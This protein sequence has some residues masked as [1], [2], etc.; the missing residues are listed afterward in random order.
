MSKLKQPDR[1]PVCYLIIAGILLTQLLL[2]ALLFHP[3]II[4]FSRMESSHWL[5]ILSAAIVVGIL[6]FLY[7]VGSSRS[8]FEGHFQ[9]TLADFKIGLRIISQELRKAKSRPDLEDIISWEF[10]SNFGLQS[11]ELSFRGWASGPYA[12]SLPLRVNNV[13]LGTLYLGSRIGGGKFTEQELAVFSELQKQVSLTLWSLE[14]DAAIQTAEELTRLK[15]KFLA[16]VTHELRTPLNGI[17]N[18]IGFVADG[19]VGPVNQ[20][21]VNLLQQALQNSEKLLEIINNILDISKIEAG[22]MTIHRRPVDLEEIVTELVP[23]IKEMLHKKPIEL[24]T[25]VSPYLP[26]LDGDRL[27]LRQI[28][29]NLLSNAAK[30]TKTGTI[31][32]NL[33]ANNGKLI[34][35]VADTGIGIEETVLPTI[36]HQFASSGLADRKQLFG[37]GLGLPITRALVEFHRG[38]IEVSSLVGEGTTVTVTLPVNQPKREVET[39]A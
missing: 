30:F 35:Q 15:S 39:E 20:K 21:Q 3:E 28:M 11:A 12:L 13:E 23:L 4:G 14:L 37:P 2:L 24:V 22:Q 6:H 38:R 34:I 31:W 27:R 10:P 33:Y 32:L 26:L 36:F 17:I 5:A 25:K 1:R 7:Y 16:N 18:Y 9:R 29:L 19:V 8:W